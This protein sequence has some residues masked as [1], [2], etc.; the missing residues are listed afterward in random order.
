MVSAGGSAVVLL[1]GL[2][3][4]LSLLQVAGLWSGALGTAWTPWAARA[5]TGLSALLAVLF[6]S[7]FAGAGRREAGAPP[8][9]EAPA[10]WPARLPAVAALGWTA[11]LW[12]R[13]WLL[14]WRRPPYDWDG[15]YYHVP[16]L[17]AWAAA[18]RICWIDT[19]PD[20]PYVNYPMGVEAT[21]FL[22]HALHRASALVDAVN[23]W[24]WPLAVAALVVLAR[25][26]G[27][28]GAWAWL[29]G[30]LLA[31]AP[32]LVGQGATAY[33][34]SAFAATVM[35]AL[36]AS[37]LLVFGPAG[38]RTRLALLWGAA[39]GLMAGAKGSGLPFAAVLTVLVA[40]AALWRRRAPAGA[41][42]PH[43]L[44][45]LA[46]AA[47]VG[48]YWYLRAALLTGNPLHPIQVAIGQKVIFPGWDHVAFSEANLPDWLAAY[49]PW[50]RTPVSWLQ[51]DAPIR[52]YAPTGGLGYLWP[53]AGLPAAVAL[54]VVL[55]RRRR[56]PARGPFLL[57]A[58]ATLL[59]LAAQT[60]TWW[61]RFTIWLLALGLPALAA[62]LSRL[63]RPGRAWPLRAAA[64]LVAA[65]CLGLAIWES[66][67][68]LRLE[69]A[70]GRDPEA[71]DVRYVSTD[72]MLFGGLWETPG[73][74]RFLA[75]PAV[76]RGPWGRLGTL[77]DGDLCLPLG[78]RRIVVLPPEP[79]AADLARLRAEGIS[80]VLWDVAGGGE[81]PATLREAAVEELVFD[82]G[83]EADFRFLRLGD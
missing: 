78:R 76:A 77:V 40:I 11:L 73:A 17:N 27:A 62:L 16:A 1:A 8:D 79:S 53:A 58:A 33:T 6:A 61:S 2:T 28:R 83:P 50:L 34:D 36:A 42:W 82:R 69:E 29:A 64:I 72:A 44:A 54:G 48:G 9:A 81:V 4:F 30:G 56:D 51:F 14:A 80:W 47:A 75:A 3:A 49:P 13:L 31:G 41:W 65:G 46:V 70:T 15:L 26:L 39:L 63:E 71:A 66:G 21:T 60:S 12:G 7:W 10:G 20:V 24:Y 23:L 19:I 45:G 74:D 5:L 38:R 18:G 57:L 43:L 22:L 67:R 68:T 59:L 52:G 35:A 32:V 55:A 25:S 37:V